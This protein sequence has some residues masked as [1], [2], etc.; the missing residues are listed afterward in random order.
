MVDN[1]LTTILDLKGLLDHIE[2][3]IQ[4]EFWSFL[5]K[6]MAFKKL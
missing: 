4:V 2:A 1:Q 6:D 5:T 3:S